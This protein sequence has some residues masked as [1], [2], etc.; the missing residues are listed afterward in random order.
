[1]IFEYYFSIKLLKYE[2]TISWDIVNGR[3]ENNKYTAIKKPYI[4]KVKETE[5]QAAEYYGTWWSWSWNWLYFE[6]EIRKLA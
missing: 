6:F 4:F 2:F 1:M 5:K 3:R